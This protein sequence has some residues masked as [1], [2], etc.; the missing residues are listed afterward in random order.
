MDEQ[1]A[2]IRLFFAYLPGDAVRAALSAA[3]GRLA[4]GPRARTVVPENYHLTIAFVGDIPASRLEAVRAIGG[5]R[6]ARRCDIS[7][8][9]Y[10]YWPK[11][12]V[13]VAAAREIPP[14]L[15]DLWAGLHRDLS[16]LELAREPKRLRPHVTLARKVSQE[17]V[18][19][20]MSAGAWA[21]TCFS[22]LRA[23]SAGAERVYT[24]VDT[25]QLLDEMPS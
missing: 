2:T 6:R 22:L 9:A 5:A 16:Q 10:E 24:V 3:A 13:V 4:L 18:L 14:A 15:A 21:L 7:F 17:P 12:E 1:L 20:A 19:Q 8:D 25:W 11:P 23:H